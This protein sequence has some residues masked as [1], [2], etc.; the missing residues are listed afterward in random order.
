LNVEKINDNTCKRKKFNHTAP[1]FSDTC[2]MT[3]KQLGCNQISKG[4]Y[5]A[6]CTPGIGFIGDS[7]NKNAIEAKTPNGAE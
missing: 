5:H 3:D 7:L 6:N 4:T 2:K 1:Y